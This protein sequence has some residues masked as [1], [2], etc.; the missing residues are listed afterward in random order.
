MMRKVLFVNKCNP[1]TII[2][3]LLSKTG[4]EVRTIYDTGAALKDLETTS[5]DMVIM[6]ENPRQETWPFC[7]GMRKFTSSPVIVISFGASAESSV[8]AIQAGADF[9]L[10]KPFGP[11]EFISRVNA[12]FQRSSNRQPVPAIS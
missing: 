5:Y 8:R 7:A 3:E 10:R 4:L 12:L 11:M 2:P 1:G 9:F 6:M